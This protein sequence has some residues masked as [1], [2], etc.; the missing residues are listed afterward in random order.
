MKQWR[1]NPRGLKMNTTKPT[2]K[3]LRQFIREYERIAAEKIMHMSTKRAEKEAIP[4]ASTSVW[5][6]G[7]GTN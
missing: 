2:D 6:S 3:E 4:E 7:T 5:G 1:H